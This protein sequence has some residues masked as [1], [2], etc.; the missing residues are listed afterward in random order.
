MSK[1]TV[2]AAPA[3]NYRYYENLKG[4]DCSRDT[5]EVARFRSPDLLNMISDN[6]GNPV[7]RMGWRVMCD[8]REQGHAG[9]FNSLYM[10]DDG[11]FY[12]M[13][14]NGVYRYDGE[15][16][17]VIDGDWRNGVIYPFNGEQYLFGNG[18]Y[19]LN[20]EVT[21]LL[22]DPYIPEMVISRSPDG[23]GGTFYESVNLLTQFRT[24]SFIGESSDGYYYLYP[25]KDLT[26]AA[27][28]YI[29]ADSIKVEV[30][31]AN[32]EFVE[33]EFELTG[34]ATIT[35]PGFDGKDT[36]IS[37]C[38]PKIK[39]TTAP[40]TAVAGQD[41][42]KITFEA[43]NT[44]TGLF[45]QSREDL[46]KANL[47]KAYGYENTDRLFVV[48]DDK[49]IRYSDVNKPTY[50][51]DDGYLMVSHKG[52]IQGLHRYQRNLVAVTDDSE[53]ESTVFFI[54]GR[55]YG[56]DTFFGVTPATSGTGAIAPRSFDTLIDEP[57]FL[58]R[59]GIYAISNTSTESRTVIR[60]R[61]FYIDRKLKEEENL[62]NAVS[63]VWNNYYILCINGHCYVLDGRNTSS[64]KGNNTNYVYESY[65]WENVPAKHLCEYQGDLYFVTEDGKL[66]KFNSD[67]KDLSKFS[68]G[69]VLEV[70][71]D[72]TKVIKDGKAICCRWST[73]LDDDG[74]AHYFKT[75][76][77]KGS[78][79]T[80]VPYEHSS[81]RVS[82]S[83]DGE[84]PI[85]IGTAY[86]DIMT[87]A[88]IDFSRFS[89]N[90][91]IHIQD[92]YF[93]KKL[94][95]YKR[96]QLIFENDTN[97]EPFGLV[98]IIKTFIVNNLAK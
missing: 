37:V 78:M 61:S 31:N 44:K 94:K 15:V 3:L 8:F 93:K 92:V 30:M 91:N 4:M 56:G 60:N 97:N 20:G 79:F 45:V 81:V 67:L 14:T 2:P 26:D 70:M 72:G 40:A 69:G 52:K 82:Y 11:V 22:E 51:P 28:K 59:N 86:L 27:Y 6:G 10:S 54:S 53:I 32:G 1:F 21:S 47:V 88:N 96:L 62:H 66:C 76:N 25:K 48:T 42:V 23:T 58:S 95:K 65:Y 80:A 13:S 68:D 77:K 75:M 9:D 35:A 36:K 34:K 64:E 71:S 74:Y 85:V 24:I 90:S 18:V 83:K 38:T 63:V 46:L 57:L 50:F 16:E 29:K 89:F 17:K 84:T 49:T 7:K 73:V 43:V 12:I 19:K 5:T 55:E 41:N 87:W 39:V 33:S 98:S